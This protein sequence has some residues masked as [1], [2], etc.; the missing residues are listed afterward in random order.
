MGCGSRA[1]G[2][3]MR[4]NL[5]YRRRYWLATVRR[6][7]KILSLYLRTIQLLFVRSLGECAVYQHM[8]HDYLNGGFILRLNKYRYWRSYCRHC[9]YYSWC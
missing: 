6:F 7:C 3:L 1:F 9:L 2:A 5:L 8:L 4:R